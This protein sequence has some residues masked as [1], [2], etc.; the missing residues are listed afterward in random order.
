MSASAAPVLAPGVGATFEFLNGWADRIFVLTLP[1]A[2]ERHAHV[3]AVLAGLDFR[4]HMG[5]DKANLDLQALER[6]GGLAPWRGRRRL[7]GKARPLT[8][9]E[10][11]AALS[12]RQIYEEIVRS[13]LR[14]AVVLEDDVAPREDDVASLPAA[15]GQLPDDWDF[16]YLGYTHY[17]RVGAVE[18]AKR[19]AYLAL[20]PL[21]LV[22]WRP[23]EALRLHPRPWSE[24]LR[25]AGYHDGAYAYAVSAE[26][27]RKLIAAQTPLAHPADHA[28]V[29]LVLSGE[30][31]AFVTE[32]K[33]F[34]ERSAAI[35]G[36][37][38]YANR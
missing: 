15:I 7:T 27:A 26:G 11:G 32:P 4:F 8:P 13:G 25:R 36:P 5:A 23:G 20:S 6:A 17:E 9:G 22:P 31:R 3:R 24:N 14:R 16:L 33:A 21:R 10:V 12:H 18:R 1:R 28:F 29:R 2:V 34:D 30:L 19:V 38:S 35:P 37:K